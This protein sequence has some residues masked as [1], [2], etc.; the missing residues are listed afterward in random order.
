MKNLSTKR[1]LRAVLKASIISGLLFGG[2]SLLIIIIGITKA[3]LPQSDGES[4]S[5][6]VIAI[7]FLVIMDAT[8][9][10]NW[11]SPQPGYWLG[12]A[13]VLINGL[14][15]AFLFGVPVAFWQFL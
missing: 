13:V 14:L 8:K 11:F 6:Y 7:P 3:P 2:L 5:V 10:G 9:L 4:E 1:K 15:G 12:L